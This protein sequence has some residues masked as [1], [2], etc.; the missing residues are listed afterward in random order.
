M[1][2]KSFKDYFDVAQLES[3]GP[4]NQSNLFKVIAWDW[5]RSQYP[6]QGLVYETHDKKKVK[7]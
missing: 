7:K 2:K 4:I 3:H 5:G 6:S 1:S